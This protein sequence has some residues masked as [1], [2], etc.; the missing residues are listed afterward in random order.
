MTD[1]IEEIS[2]KK[3][4]D[5][6]KAY[7]DYLAEMDDYL[8]EVEGLEVEDIILQVCAKDREIQFGRRIAHLNSRALLQDSHK[9]ISDQRASIFREKTGIYLDTAGVICQVVSIASGGVFSAI[10]HACTQTTKHVD[11]AAGARRE[12]LNFRYDRTRD[13]IGDHNQGTQSSKRGEDENNSKIDHIIQI[14]GKKAEL[15][16]GS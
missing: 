16:A 5:A 1:S 13:V 7:A 6:Y 8:E 3:R 2:A 11:N 15:I 9:E 12:A 4:V 10:G 14:L